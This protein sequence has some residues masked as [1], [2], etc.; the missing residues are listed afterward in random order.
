MHSFINLTLNDSSLTSH[1]NKSTHDFNL[2]NFFFNHIY[3]LL[4][5]IIGCIG[6]SFVII[7][8]GQRALRTTIGSIGSNMSVY[9]F[10]F[11]MAISDTIYL[12]ILFCLWLSNYINILHR[13]IICQLTLYLTYVCN[14]INAYYTVSFTAQRLFAV[15]QP[16]RVS[17]VLSWYRSKCLA[18]CIIIFACLIYSYLPFLVGIVNG[19]C[20]SLEHLRWINK[21]MDIIDCIIVF[22]IPYIMIITMN[23]I[24]LISLRRMKHIQHEYL[25]QNNSQLNKIREITRRNASRKMTKLL[26]TVSTSYL[27]VCGP[28]ACIHTWRLLYNDE[29]FQ[30]KL[31]RQLEYYFHLI[32]HISFA[33]NF[34]IYIV[35]GSK[36]RHELKRFLNKC[37]INFNHC[38]QND[39][40]DEQDT[41]TNQNNS[42]TFEQFQLINQNT[43]C[44][45]LTTAGFTFQYKWKHPKGSYI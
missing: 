1:L 19:Q 16:F 35:F 39:S 40:F 12:S 23:T 22:L 25:F 30:T 44:P 41:S 17:L 7:V 27:I 42:S 10:L 8:F 9:P 2:L 32:Y 31:L 28:Y 38:F 36:F 33:M 21:L 18:L 29:K 26:L 15:V 37:Q 6:N 4:L 3:L 13:P 20:Y 43:L 14:F 24:I 45:T 5:V 34:Y 11:Y